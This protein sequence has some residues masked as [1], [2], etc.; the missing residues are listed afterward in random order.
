[1][2]AQCASFARA[3]RV[4]KKNK[5]FVML[6]Q[7]FRILEIIEQLRAIVG[8]VTGEKLEV[9]GIVVIGSQSSGKSSLLEHATGLAFPR[10][11][12]MCTR[13]PTVVSVQG[14]CAKASLTVS[15]NPEYNDDSTV[16]LDPSDTKGFGDA[17]TMFTNQLTNEGE[18]SDVPIYVRLQQTTGPTFTLT[19][20][21]GITH[22]GKR[23]ANVG[24]R[25]RKGHH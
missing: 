18:I 12:G 9:P 11:E 15:T 22:G 14:G 16:T 5:R 4:N 3:T 7:R 10:G 20:V 13:V 6:K 19:D 25:N 2:A 23:N 8:G 24:R 21:P 17:I 1:M